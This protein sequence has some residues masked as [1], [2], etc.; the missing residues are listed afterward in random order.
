[1][2]A[3]Q[4]WTF[5]IVFAAG[6]AAT[7]AAEPTG[8]VIEVS[9]GARDRD[10]T[11]VVF[12]LPGALASARGLAMEGLDDRKPVP[13]QLVGG[14]TPAAAWIERGLAAGSGRKYRLRAVPPS[15]GEP[16]AV[17]VDDGKA[18]LIRVGGRP[19]LR[20][21]HATVEPPAG[22]DPA[23]RRS[24]YLHPLFTPAGKVVTGDFAEDHPHQHG[25]FFAW[26]STQFNGHPLNFWDQLGKTGRV[27][28]AELIDTVDGPVF[29]QLSAR[30]RHEDITGT[31]P[32]PVLD[33]VWTVRAFAVDGLA[34]F[35][36]ESR[37]TTAGRRP[38]QINKYVYGGLG[39]RGNSA[40]F[41]PTVK[42]EAPPDPARSGASDFLTSEGKGRADGNHTRPRWVN[43]SGELD[44]SVA[45][46]TVLGH[47][48]N[49]RAPQPVRLHPNKPYFSLAPAV[50]GAFAIEP[51]Q[52][53]VSKYRVVLHDGPAD[54]ARFD[55][56]WH[57]AAE[58][59]M[60]RVVGEE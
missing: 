4:L 10:Q 59:P 48:D 57:D 2:N 45:G 5:L 8:V 11:P 7:R 16:A 14:E 51:G 23:Y 50:L 29:A 24:G 55:A 21:N 31:E 52:T 41:D 15:S 53:Y 26:T 33:E 32:V 39:F 3:R 30:L 60:V 20:Y 37:Q 46:I 35:D 58:P 44:G 38:L 42:G 22:Q 25:L 49:F 34:L 56:L 54:S 27:R 36:L 19:V 6:P 18:V 9:A 47:P 17:C 40:W 1:M 28:H 43:Y 13:V 12:P